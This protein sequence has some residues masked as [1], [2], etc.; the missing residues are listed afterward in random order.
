LADVLPGN[1]FPV[2]QRCTRNRDTTDLDRPQQSYGRELSRTTYGN[3]DP[4]KA[5]DLLTRLELI[6]EG[7]TGVV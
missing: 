1:L 2:V 5:R 7:P 4:L 3:R 6:R